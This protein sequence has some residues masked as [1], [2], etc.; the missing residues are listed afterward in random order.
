MGTPSGLSYHNV[1]GHKYGKSNI[2][3]G[4]ASFYI[5]IGIVLIL[6]LHI[7]TGTQDTDSSKEGN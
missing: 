7:F 3:P 5:M 2:P 1:V 4:T 6:I